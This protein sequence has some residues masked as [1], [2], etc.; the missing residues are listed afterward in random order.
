MARPQ[1]I[2][3]LRL[4][5]ACCMLLALAACAQS[6]GGTDATPPPDAAARGQRT[7]DLATGTLDLLLRSDQ[8]PALR[9]ALDRCRGV[10]IAPRFVKAGFIFGGTGGHAVLLGH[11]PDGA[12]SAP[13]FVRLAGGSAGFQA[14]VSETAFIL[15]ALDDATFASLLSN[16]FTFDAELLAAAPGKGRE[17]QTSSMTYDGGA[18]YFSVVDGLFAGV[19]LDGT[20]IFPDTDANEAYYAPGTT[21]LSL[22]TGNDHDAGPGARRLLN[23]LAAPGT[24]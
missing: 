6:G 8:G 11:R 4:F 13:A 18:A 20:G 22:T 12:W 15:A 23:L 17:R 1:N 21:P 19:A 3:R 7:L 14:G 16:G 24:D 9:Q 10:L 2:S 5:A